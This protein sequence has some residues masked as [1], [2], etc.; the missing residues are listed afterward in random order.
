MP[1]PPSP[2]GSPMAAER[3]PIARNTA[4]LSGGLACVYGMSQLTAAVATLTFV[5]VTGIEKLLGV[6]PAIVLAA[7]ALTALP[8]GRAMDRYGRVPVLAAG[9][10]VG[11]AGT[12]LTGLGALWTSIP[13][14]IFGFMFI[15]AAN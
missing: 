9:F 4:L 3:L 1:L 14:V 12:I 10:V 13:L 8:A 11:A 6:G 7:N 5:L 2:P 15:G